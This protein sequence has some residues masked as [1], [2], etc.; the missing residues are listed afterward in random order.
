LRQNVKVAIPG[1]RHVKIDV[2]VVGAFY[3][4]QEQGGKI[5]PVVRR[6]G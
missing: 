3:L 2:P 1:Y 4:I 6:M 5:T